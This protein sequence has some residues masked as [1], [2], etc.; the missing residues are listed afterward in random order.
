M[1][2]ALRLSLFYA[3]F[4]LSGGI[5]LP[6]WPVWLTSRG[7]TPT[8]LGVVLAIGQWIKVAATLVTGGVADRSG[9]PRRVMQILA[10]AAVAGYVACIPAH[11]FAALATLNALTAACLAALLPVGDALAITATRQ[12]RADFGRVRLWG[13]IAFIAAT[14]LG[15]RILTG[16]A[17]DVILALV[18]ALTAVNV[19]TCLLL[20]RNPTHLAAGV[21]RGSAWRLMLT[22]RH[23]I[24]LAVSTLIAASHSVYYGFG[25]LWWKA[26]GFSDA[27]IA[28]LWAEG[29]AA[30]AVFLYFG[31]R[32]VA[33]CGPVPLMALGAASGA[34]RWTAL[35]FTADLRVLV[36]AQLLHAGTVAAAGLGGIHYLGRT[37]PPGQAA[38]GQAITAAVV[39]G[40]GFGVF[41]PLAG[42]LYGAYG[43]GAYLAMAALSAAA[44]VAA[45]ALD[46]LTAAAPTN[47]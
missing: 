32:A 10:A 36:L 27:T 37:I 25:S 28:W 39:G 22:R 20:P 13:T 6:F 30:E 47:S 34:L 3:G 7:L 17:A 45:L 18:I 15:G 1:P 42:V 19:G 9:D 29:A 23:L 4:F 41:M 16:R 43:G 14:L 12:G 31:A 44:A 2:S 38:T 40:F 21:T 26:Q 5:L 11:G 33:R 35:A 24:F 8:E 46:R